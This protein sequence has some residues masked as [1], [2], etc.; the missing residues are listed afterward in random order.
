MTP[1]RRLEK[2]VLRL[3]M[4]EG[5]GNFMPNSMVIRKIDF[6]KAITLKTGVEDFGI[7]IFDF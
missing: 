6:D 7:S 5:N 1:L 3:R 2:N 4:S